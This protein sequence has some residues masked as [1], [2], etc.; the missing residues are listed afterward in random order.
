M[1]AIGVTQEQLEKAA[2]PPSGAPVRLYGLRPTAKGWRFTLKTYTPTGCNGRPAKA[3]TPYRRLSQHVD[4]KKDGTPYQR[5]VPGAVCWHGHRDFF[6]ALYKLAPEAII[7]TALATYRNSRHFEEAFPG[8][9][10]VATDSPRMNTVPYD[11]ACTC[12][13]S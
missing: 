4:R 5:T 11:Q 8:T 13:P 9:R 7:K 12:H 1:E 10:Q 2:G 3:A 6:R